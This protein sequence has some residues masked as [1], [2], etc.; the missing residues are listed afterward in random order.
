VLAL[1][2]VGMPKF[3]KFW[4]LGIALFLEVW[5]IMKNSDK[6]RSPLYLLLL[7]GFWILLDVA[8]A[9]PNSGRSVYSPD[10]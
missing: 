5:V 4:V 1:P 8:Q 3:A 9:P 2:I 6:T 10:V 7:A